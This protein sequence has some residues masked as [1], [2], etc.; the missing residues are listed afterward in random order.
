[1][2]RAAVSRAALIVGCLTGSVLWAQTKDPADPAHAAK[3]TKGLEVF[4]QHVRPLLEQKCLRCHGGKSVE[5]DFDLSDREHLLKGGESGPAVRLGKSKESLLYKLIT[6]SKEPFMPHQSKKLPDDVIAHIAAW[7]DLGAPYD[8]S[9]KAAK[10]TSISWT[11]KTLPDEARRFWS[12]QPLRR[13]PPPAVRNENWCRTIPDR[14]IL[15]KLEAAG[16]T[17]NPAVDKR[18]LVR[19]AYF[20]LLGLPPTPDEV[21]GFLSDTSADAYDKLLD[22][23]LG[24]VH[25]GERWARHWLDV[26]RFAESHGFEHD[27]D[28]PTAYHYRDFVIQALNNDLPYDTFVK[29]QIAGDEY[30]P[31]NNLALTATGFLAAGVHSTQITKNEVEKHRYDEMDDM[32]ATIGTSMLG[33]T[34]GCARC[35]DHKFDPIPQAD[36]YR[37][38]STFT[39]TVRSE[40]DL[41]LV[42][43]WIQKAKADVDKDHAHYAAALKKYETEML[44]SR[45]LALEKAWESNPERF[46]WPALDVLQSKGLPVAALIRWSKTSDPEWRKLYQQAHDHQQKAPKP[47]TLKALISSEG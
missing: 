10:N 40:I 30:A 20:D 15:A 1:M 18:Q 44:P 43:A 13:A 28:R 7:I 31:N 22:R 25:Y 19:R 32:L 46:A 6:H 9:L 26:A 27:Y 37:M 23:L 39:T 29:W 11:Q 38:L 21:N 24:S 12:F 45:R 35:H 4:K 47:K 5:S 3:M 2:A 16:L 33:L 8:T 36:Y 34:F 17:P 41:D 42:P 14:F